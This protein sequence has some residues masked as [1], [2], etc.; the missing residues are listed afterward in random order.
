MFNSLDERIDVKTHPKYMVVINNVSKYG[1]DYD[2]KVVLQNPDYVPP[3]TGSNLSVQQRITDFKSQ[4]K[5]AAK[6]F[7]LFDKVSDDS[8][9]GDKVWKDIKQVVCSGEEYSSEKWFVDLLD[10]QKR[11]VSDLR[12]MQFE[13]GL[14]S[15]IEPQENRIR[16]KFIEDR[17]DELLPEQNFIFYKIFPE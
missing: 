6:R 9:I 3:L 1:D 15:P 2:P 8:A 4:V 17:I 10:H 5:D 7:Y 14:D 13:I 12:Q 11:L 16:A